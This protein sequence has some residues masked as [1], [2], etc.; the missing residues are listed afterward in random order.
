MVLCFGERLVEHFVSKATTRVVGARA[1][2]RIECLAPLRW[3]ATWFDVGSDTGV[4][5]RTHAVLPHPRGNAAMTEAPSTRAR[6]V[7][8]VVHDL[9]TNGTGD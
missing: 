7:S 8:R 5:Q 1:L 3:R 4:A 2:E 6:Q 9:L